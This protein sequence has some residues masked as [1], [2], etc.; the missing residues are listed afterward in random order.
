MA[1]PSASTLGEALA[2]NRS[3]GSISELPL[4]LLSSEAAAEEVQDSAVLAFDES[5]VGYFVTAT[6]AVT[7]RVLQCDM[8]IV[9]P[10]A[11]SAMMPNLASFKLPWGILGAEWSMGFILG[12]HY[13]QSHRPVV[14]SSFEDS[15]VGCIPMI[16]VLGRRV[17]SAIP[18]NPWTATAD[19][20]LHAMSA[21]G[22]PD[23][24]M[25][26]S[27][28]AAVDVV[29]SMNDAI[30]GRT[31]GA[32][33]MGDLTG[34]AMKLAEALARR[35]RQLSPGNIVAIGGGPLIFQAVAGQTFRA[36]F[37]P[38]GTVEVEFI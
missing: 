1:L 32:D 20:G 9:G 31:R 21:K 36:D 4:H 3:A 37:G 24:E 22:K 34:A 25:R 28:L 7:Q 33:F 17:T 35:E 23:F 10:L 16:T 38:L 8:P 11:A 13:P 26:P 19:F 15:V 6:T 5:V 29:V 12:A 27:N 30:V 14:A 2:S 18:L